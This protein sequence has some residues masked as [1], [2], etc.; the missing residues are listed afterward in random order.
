MNQPSFE[1]GIPTPVPGVIK[2]RLHR[3]LASGSHYSIVSWLFL[4]GLALIYLAA[5]ASMSVQIEGLIGSQGILPIQPKLTEIAQ[6]YTNDKYLEFPTLFWFAAS[7]RAL[8]LVCYAGIA[9]SVLLLLNVLLLPALILCY[10]L[11]LSVTVAGQDFLS[12]QWDVFLLEAG[13]MGIFL[14]WGSEIMVF[15][16]R[17]LIARFMFMGGLV[18][19]ASGDPT[20]ANLTALNYHYL[21]EPLPSPLAYYAYF[22]PEWFH[23]LCVAGV[24]VIE[25]IVPFF[26]FL[27]RPFR[28]FAAWSF[29]ALQSAIILTGNYNFFNLLTILLCLWLFDDRDFSGRLP[30]RLVARIQKNQPQPGFAAHVFAGSWT[31]LVLFVCA[32]TAWMHNTEGRTPQPL[33][34]LVLMTSTFSVINQYGPFAVMTTER[35]EII[36]EGS[37]DGKTWQAYEF[38]Y[39]PGDLS[40]A[41][42]WNIPHQPRLDWQLWFAAL[43]H[44]RLDSWFA[45]FMARLQEGSPPVLALLRFNPFPDH[46]PVFVRAMLYRYDYSRPEVRK[47]TGHIWRRELL[48]QYWPPPYPELG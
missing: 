36:I 47:E 46:P 8:R 1:T 4:R 45:A 21:T 35:P 15:L 16:Y 29:I 11:Y 20:W 39:K 42:R 9:A 2:R 43:R 41:L 18:K 5:F 27:P 44:P 14:Y 40:R 24:F 26:V 19:L 38:N 28:L 37:N 25:L 13:F 12:F 10:L 22:L 30:T 33:R 7:D 17:W 48:G 34:S 32:V 23:K 31:L 6:F 3:F